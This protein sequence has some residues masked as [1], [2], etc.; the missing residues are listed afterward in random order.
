MDLKQLQNLK[1]PNARLVYKS[2]KHSDELDLNVELME[3]ERLIKTE[4]R[5]QWAHSHAYC[6]FFRPSDD[7]QF[8]TTLFWLAREVIGP[9]NEDEEGRFLLQDLDAA[10]VLS[11]EMSSSHPWPQWSE[12]RAFEQSARAQIQKEKFHNTQALAPTWRLEWDLGLG[13][14]LCRL[15]FFLK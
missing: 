3:L 13:D 7:P 12:C 8:Q 15:Q 6:Y 14:P 9:P 5:F 1:T 4:T 10:E 2:L 11:L